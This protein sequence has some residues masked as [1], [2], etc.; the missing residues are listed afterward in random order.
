M[1]ATSHAE[2][3][4]AQLAARTGL[5]A[6]TLRMWESRHGFPTPARLPGGHRR[7]STRDVEAVLEVLRLRQQGLSLPAAIDRARR[8]EPAGHESVFAGLR[9]RCPEIAVSALVKPAVLQISHAIEDE[10]LAR[11]ARG[12]VFGS[13]QHERFYR[14]AE[15]RW[16]ELART[17]ELA[18]AI[19]NFP[20]IHEPEA[21]DVAPSEVPVQLRHPLAREWT[22][23]IDA[24]GAHA[25]LAA[26]EMPSQDELPDRARR[27]ETMWSFEPEVVRTASELATDLL[28][29]LAPSI[30]PRVPDLGVDIAVGADELRFADALSQRVVGYL[31]AIVG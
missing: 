20:E 3:S 31:G 11:A 24:P 13:F 16:R 12:L 15:R 22:L 28:W 8:Q 4:T 2:L 14:I 5:P 6:G 7:Y 26:W 17:A 30:A 27:F 18:V 29:S 25:C 23:V 19:A 21:D 9:R 10:Y 1:A